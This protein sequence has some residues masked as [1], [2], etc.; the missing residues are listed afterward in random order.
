MLSQKITNIYK[1]YQEFRNFSHLGDQYWAERLSQNNISPTAIELDANTHQ[2]L[3]KPLNIF[4]SKGQ[5]DFILKSDIFNRAKIL[6][7]VLKTK[8]YI[9][10]HNNLIAELKGAKFIIESEQD[11]SIINEIYFLGIYNFVH[12]KPVVVI[13]IGMNVGFAS[14]Y[15]ASRSNV[16]AV[17]GYEP[18][19]ITYKQ[20]LNNFALNPEIA[21][22]IKPYQYGIAEQEQTLTIEFDYDVKGSIGMSGIDNNFKPSPDKKIATAE[23]KLKATYEVFQSII[24]QYPD[25]D[26]IAKVDCEGAE[27]EIF[28]VLSETGQINRI[29]MVMMEWHK[30]GPEPLLNYLNQ[31]GFASFSRLPASNN[32]GFLYA[33]K[34]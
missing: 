21:Q 26:I 34:A 31:A 8:F 12:E 20:A 7:N 25:V 19:E 10:E 11:I 5:H 30:K 22:K 1:K 28:K 29:K 27:Y 13:D 14:L 24:K 18:F 33:I 16:L 9:D 6:Q 3:L 2:L 4:L 17:F 32:I 15:F 23:M